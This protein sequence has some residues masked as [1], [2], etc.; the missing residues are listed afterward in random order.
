MIQGNVAAQDN[1][2]PTAP[3]VQTKTVKQSQPVYSSNL[4]WGKN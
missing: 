3:T 1:E 2:L 4:T